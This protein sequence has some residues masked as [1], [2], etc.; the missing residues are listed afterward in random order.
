MRPGALFVGTWTLASS[1]AWG[2]FF[3]LSFLL[4][5]LGLSLVVDDVDAVMGTHLGFTL[6]LAFAFGLAGGA[7]GAAQAWLLRKVGIAAGWRWALGGAVAWGS[8]GLVYAALEPFV[9]RLG[10]ELIHNVVAGV[11]GGLLQMRTLTA[12]T[13]R[14]RYWPIVLAATFLVG[15]FVAWGTESATGTEVGDLMPLVMFLLMAITGA[16]I[17]WMLREQPEPGERAEAAV[18]S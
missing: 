18:A 6:G 2:V 7:Q 17:A 11:L 9:P 16:S 15:G 14:G 3:F 10:N 5:G 12:A 1:V 8:L 4:V 13:P